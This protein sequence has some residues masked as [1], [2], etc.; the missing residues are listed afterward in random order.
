MYDSVMAVLSVA[1]VG[2]ALRILA[3]FFQ[4]C[5]FGSALIMKGM[6][7]LFC[8]CPVCDRTFRRLYGDRRRSDVRGGD[9]DLTLAHSGR[10]RAR[11]SLW[12]GKDH[13]PLAR[14][15]RAAFLVMSSILQLLF[16]LGMA[17]LLKGTLQ[18]VRF[19]VSSGSVLRIVRFEHR[20]LRPRPHAPVDICWSLWLCCIL[21]HSSP[22]VCLRPGFRPNCR[23]HRRRIPWSWRSSPDGL[24]LFSCGVSIG[25]EWSMSGR[26]IS[27]ENADQH[28]AFDGYPSKVPAETR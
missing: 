26:I 20:C 18:T 2:G 10:F 22:S 28:M 4:K 17:F 9:R 8:S 15:C 5:V 3:A 7:L 14:R 23:A 13:E 16:F 25:R 21:R 12:R 11:C 27:K 19:P 6:S 24:S 1:V